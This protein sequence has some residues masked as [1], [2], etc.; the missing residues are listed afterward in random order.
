[1][2]L[3]AQSRFEKSPDQASELQCQYYLMLVCPGPL[4]SLG[5]CKTAASV[6]CSPLDSMHVAIRVCIKHQYAQRKQ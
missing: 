2:Y 6:T 3:S 1:M 5:P 4:P